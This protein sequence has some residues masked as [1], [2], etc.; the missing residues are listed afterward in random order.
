MSVDSAMFQYSG[1]GRSRLPLVGWLA[2]SR[3]FEVFD[4]G[5]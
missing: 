2:Y 3:R 5:A 1:S 4:G